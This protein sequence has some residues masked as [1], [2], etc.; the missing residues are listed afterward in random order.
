MV[1]GKDTSAAIKA[2]QQFFSLQVDGTFGPQTRGV[3]SEP[4]CGIPDLPHG[5]NFSVAGPCNKRHLKYAFGVLSRQPQMTPD[6]DKPPCPLHFDDGEHRWVDGAVAGSFDVETI[7]LHELRHIL[8]LYHSTSL[9]AVMYAATINGNKTKRTLQL[10][11]I[12]AIRNMYPPWQFLGGLWS[13]KLDFFASHH[14]SHLTLQ[15]TAG[16]PAVCAR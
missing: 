7:A 8:G 15:L 14:P 11:D 4:R 12:R 6:V 9:G 3:M 13:G 2:F 16:I 10:D 5:V 1:V